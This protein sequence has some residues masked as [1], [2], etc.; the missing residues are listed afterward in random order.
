MYKYVPYLK[1]VGLECGRLLILRI[2]LRQGCPGG[3]DVDG[4][5]RVQPVVEKE[6]I[7]PLE[8]H[9]LLYDM[10]GRLV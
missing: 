10:Q 7:Y 2:S 9:C 3:E 5:R 8:C 4:V 1:N 6:T